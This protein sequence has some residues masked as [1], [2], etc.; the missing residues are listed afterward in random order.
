MDV[1]EHLN[2][3]QWTYP[4]RSQEISIHTHFHQHYEIGHRTLTLQWRKFPMKLQTSLV[5]FRL[6]SNLMNILETF[7]LFFFSLENRSFKY[8]YAPPAEMVLEDITGTS[9]FT[10]HLGRKEKGDLLIGSKIGIDFFKEKIWLFLEKII[11]S[12]NIYFSQDFRSIRI[13]LYTFAAAI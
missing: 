12:K 11:F 2:L 6:F 1:N 8:S 10:L 5:I 7:F 9:T 4:W 13:S 3:S